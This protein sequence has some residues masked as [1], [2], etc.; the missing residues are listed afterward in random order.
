MQPT[1]APAIRRTMS[2]KPESRLQ[3]KI[4]HELEREVGGFW[5]KVHGS[6]YQDAG[7]PDLIGCRGGLFFGFEVKTDS[8]EPSR[9][10]LETIKKI[11]MNGGGVA[12][13]VTTPEEAIFLVRQAL[14]ISEGRR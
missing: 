3:L 9:I 8:G 13:V 5:F 14:A 6:E 12:S 10:Q 11:K 1:V 2:K 4:R 7:L